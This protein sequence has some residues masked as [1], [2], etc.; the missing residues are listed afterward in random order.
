MKKYKHAAKRTRNK[1]KE[2]EERRKRQFDNS[3]LEKH[4]ES[5]LDKHFKE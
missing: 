2:Y 4:V 3:K 1:Q 5:E